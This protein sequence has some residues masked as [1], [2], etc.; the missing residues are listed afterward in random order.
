[1]H[2]LFILSI[3]ILTIFLLNITKKIKQKTKKILRLQKE[4]ERLKQEN[5]YLKA[6]NTYLHFSLTQKEHRMF[7]TTAS[8]QRIQLMLEQKGN[9][10]KHFTVEEREMLLHEIEM[11]YE[12]YVSTLRDASPALT[13]EDI[14]FSC[15]S[16]LKLPIDIIGMCMGIVSPEALKQRKHRVKKKQKEHKHLCSL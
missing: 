4:N 1:L 12:I 2:I 7:K 9:N 3:S 13:D 15:L 11:H 5:H 16:E 8:Y 10:R 6:E 14:V